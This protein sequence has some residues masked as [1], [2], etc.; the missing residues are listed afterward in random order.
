MGDKSVP[1]TV[2]C[3]NSSPK[4]LSSMSFRRHRLGKGGIHCPYPCS[5]AQ[6]NNLLSIRIDWRQ[7]KLP[8]EQHSQHMMSF[9]VSHIIESGDLGL[10][11]I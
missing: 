4:S 2:A 10:P 8:V 6:V 7:E 5:R 1:V 9:T 3:G 11:D